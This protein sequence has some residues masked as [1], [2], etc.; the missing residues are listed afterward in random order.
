MTTTYDTGTI[1]VSNGST[2]V[3]GVGTNWVAGGIL[4]GDDF[5]AA[6]LTVEIAAVNSATSITLARAWPGGGQT[7]AN[8]SV[9]LI[10]AGERSLKAL[11]DIVAALG[12]GRRGGAAPASSSP[13]PV[14]KTSCPG[15]SPIG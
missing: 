8:Y 15:Y 10:D 9:R 1:S 7:S 14:T 4:P 6:G 11:N 2:T 5:R 13:S 12:S 3:T